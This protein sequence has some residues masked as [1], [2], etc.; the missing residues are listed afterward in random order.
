VKEQRDQEQREAAE[1]ERIRLETARREEEQRQAELQ[2]KQRQEQA[3]RERQ[4]QERAQR[5]RERKEKEL[6]ERAE[7]EALQKEAEMKEKQ[8]RE[9]PE[10]ERRDEEEKERLL[11]IAEKTEQLRQQELTKKEQEAQTQRAEQQRQR[12]DQE[13]ENQLP[14]SKGT[15]PDTTDREP[16]NGGF[17]D[18]DE[19]MATTP[20]EQPQTIPERPTSIL[21]LKSKPRSKMMHLSMGNGA[22]CDDSSTS[23]A[24]QS[25]LELLSSRSTGRTRRTLTTQTSDM[26]PASGTE[27]EV[28]QL[29]DTTT[30]RRTRSS[31]NDVSLPGSI[32]EPAPRPV[33][34]R[35]ASKKTK[36]REIIGFKIPSGDLDIM[37]S[38]RAMRNATMGGTGGLT[39]AVLGGQ[40]N[41]TGAAE[42]H[43]PHRVPATDASRATAA[44]A[45]HASVHNLQQ[46]AGTATCQTSGPWT[47]EALDLFAWRPPGW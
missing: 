14:I 1:R 31:P 7:R 17:L 45:H 27:A 18:I 11:K 3:Q 23:S 30:S 36:S 32:E 35:F 26:Q 42:P 25:G 22:P 8:E 9:K 46:V 40:P 19:L 12:D 47:S 37:G 41:E 16:G 2:E 33:V 10:R 29:L 21:R 28:T 20:A 24:F 5:E 34:S 4:R 38:I 13:K 43:A 39:T 15:S 44:T 6:R